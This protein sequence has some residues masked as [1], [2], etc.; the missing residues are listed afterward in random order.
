MRVKAGTA[1][2][3]FFALVL[4]AS[5]AWADTAM[6]VTASSSVT[7]RVDC[8]AA[9]GGDG[10]KEQP[11]HSITAALPSARAAAAD[12][13]VTIDVAAGVCGQETLPIEL[14]FPVHVR[15]SRAAAFDATGLPLDDQDHDTLVTWTPPSPVPASV[16]Q[17]AFFR[18]TAAKVRISKLSIDGQIVPPRR[19]FAPPVPAPMGVLAHNASSFALERLRIVGASA[20]VRAD[21]ASGVV[22]DSY[23]GRI[24]DGFVVSGGPLLAP[25]AVTIENNRIDDY[26]LVGLAIGGAGPVGKSIRATVTGNDV[27]TSYVNTGP[28]N[29]A[30]VRVGPVPFGPHLDGAVDAS[31]VSNAFRGTSRFGIIVNSPNTVRR[32]DGLHYTGTVT[33]SFDANLLERESITRAPS[34]VT[35]TNSRA[36]HFPCELN[37]ESTR[38]TC[39]SLMG[40]PPRYWEYLERSRFDLRHTGELDGALIDHPAAEPSDGRVLGNEL[41]I[42]GATVENQTFVVVP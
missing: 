9:S 4:G 10:S 19:S 31:F 5:S 27:V 17:L 23:I 3:V 20:A 39:P 6:R 13:K 15:G 34:L 41:V 30:A 38:E 7:V 8:A 21:G 16:N 1:A 24:A 26:S 40:N 37:P 22:R 14:D 28:S 32:A 18:I 29:P 11:F 25:P 42:N 2:A 33:A 12:G 35:F 36:T